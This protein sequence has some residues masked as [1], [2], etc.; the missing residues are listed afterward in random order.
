MT[1]EAIILCGGQSH[2]LK[3][4]TDISKPLLKLTPDLTLVDYQIQWLQTHGF[5]RIILASKDKPLT[6][7]NVEYST[8]HTD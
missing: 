4:H 2:R 3:P 1:R 7:L 6:S 8:K 5:E